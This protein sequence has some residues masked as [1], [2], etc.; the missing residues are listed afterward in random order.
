MLL[1]NNLEQSKYFNIK[2]FNFLKSFNQILFYYLNIIIKHNMIIL[3]L[4]L[5]YLLIN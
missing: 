2:I 3:I 5:I 1:L 4:Y